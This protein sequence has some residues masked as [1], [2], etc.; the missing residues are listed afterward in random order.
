V[1]EHV[2]LRAESTALERKLWA[3]L[4]A[5]RLAAYKFRRQHPTGP[6]CA[7]FCCVARRL[8]IEVDSSQHREEQE[9]RKDALR[10][11]HLAERGYRVIRFSN[12]QVS[13][14]LEDVLQAIYEAL[15]NS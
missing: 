9:K 7:D 8:V 5:K 13:T 12:E 15:N 3:H 2:S 14:D 4:R 11:A 6:Y 1:I 10:T